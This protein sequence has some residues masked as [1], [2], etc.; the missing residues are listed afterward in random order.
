MTVRTE[1][2][3]KRVRTYLGGELV[4]DSTGSL[5]V[6]ENPHYPAYY[7]PVGDV[8]VELVPTNTVT[9]SASR[10][11]ATHYTVRAGGKEAVDAVWRYADSPIEGLRDH[12]RFD[13]EAMDSWFEEDE[14]I[15]VHARSPYTRI[16]ALASSRH[17]RVLVN[18][19]VVADSTRPT[20]LFETG[21][22]VRYYLP[23]SDV[24]MDLLEPTEST[25]RCPYK[26][27]ARYWSVRAGGEVVPD[28]AWSYP[29][30]LPESVKV[31]GLIAFYDERVDI[32]VDGR[33]APSPPPR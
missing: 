28:V 1:P 14:E 31:A 15:F 25:S 22:P 26:G 8:R 7:V 29:F 20:L 11:D 9:H 23:K 30:P 6:W 2:G 27:V 24:R 16:D 18:E 4:A 5:L 19:E 3:Q 13:F 21:L 17:V 10:G 33:L 32:D 12:V